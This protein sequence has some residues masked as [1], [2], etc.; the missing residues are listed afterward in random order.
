MIYRMILGLAICSLSFFS[1]A[2]DNSEMSPEEEK[3]I[4]WAKG[5]WDSL[6]R[7]SGV[8][9]IDQANAVLNIPEKFYYLGPEDSETVLVEVWG[10]PPS[11]NTLGML[12][13]ADTTPFDSD[14]WAV[15]IEYEEDGYVSDE[16]ADDIDYNDLL[17]QMKDDTQSSS[18]E[19]VKEGYEPIEL[20]GWA[21]PPFYDVNEKK[22]HWAKEIK[23]GDQETNTLNY[24]I[25]VLGRK[26]VLVL[27]FIAD[28]DQKATIDANISD[29]LA[30]AEFDQG[31]KY[32][33][34]NPEIDEV[35]AY[36]LGALVAGKV[37]AKTGF[38]AMALLFLK[39]FG[40]FILL[41]L[42]TLFGKLFSRKKA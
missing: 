4:T 5:I 25:R 7:K 17:S 24:N 8:V 13:P 32:S 1:L 3:Y 2:E 19:R 18:N 29:V 23:F 41:G 10:N 16:D 14:S 28:M 42:G 20:I 39:K 37:I 35:A 33:D 26:G 6:D 27:N 30:V 36:G 15:T 34:F 12:F 22:L 9:K 21:S 11:Q 38:L 40:V 31:S